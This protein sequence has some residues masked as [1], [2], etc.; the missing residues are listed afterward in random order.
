MGQP[1]VVANDM[2]QAVCVGHLIIGPLGVPVP[3]PP[4]PFAAP[5]TL[6]LAPTVLVGGLPVAVVGSSGY[7]MPPHVGLHAS[8]PKMA[9]PLQEATIVVGS[10]T[11]TSGGQGLAYTGCSATACI[12]PGPMVVGSGARVLVGS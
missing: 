11:V 5:L 9:P 6:G 2:V 8:D 3:G 12:A 4:F 7:N 10:A 1:A